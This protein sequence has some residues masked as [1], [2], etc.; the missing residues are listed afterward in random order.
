MSAINFQIR[1][2]FLTLST[3]SWEVLNGCVS[4]AVLLCCDLE[5]TG[6]LAVLHIRALASVLLGEHKGLECAPS[7]S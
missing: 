3:I 6:E 7:F 4:R 2:S 5:L 1:D